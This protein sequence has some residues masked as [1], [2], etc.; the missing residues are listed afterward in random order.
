[1]DI[2]KGI[3]KHG[4]R[5]WHERTLFGSFGWMALTL[6]CAV[7][8][9]AAL[10]SLINSQTLGDRVLNTVAIAISAPIGIVA[11]QRF[12][13]LMVRAQTAAS[14]ALCKQCD[15]YGR[16][17]VVSEDHNASCTRVRC[18]NCEHE[19]TMDDG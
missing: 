4:F 6:L 3:R 11:F 5:T 9:L 12:L 10:E 19:W 15:T 8:S 17:A 16:L 13:R 7:A 2:A 14:Q 18:R 1:M